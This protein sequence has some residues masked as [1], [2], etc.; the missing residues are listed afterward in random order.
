MASKADVGTT[1]TRKDEDG[2]TP[3]APRNLEWSS[4][5]ANFNQ[6]PAHLMG[7]EGGAAPYAP[8]PRRIPGEA[9]KLCVTYEC[10]LIL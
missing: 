4:K 8:P 10:C 7:A 1:A 5:L 6:M 2:D 9:R 3:P